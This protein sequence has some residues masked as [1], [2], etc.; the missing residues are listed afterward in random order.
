M[1]VR[2][3]IMGIK[4]ILFGNKT[5]IVHFIALKNE[6]TGKVDYYCGMER[7]GGLLNKENRWKV[8]DDLNE[9]YFFS[10]SESAHNR[11]KL[12]NLDN[13]IHSKKEVQYIAI[14]Q[15]IKIK[16]DKKRNVKIWSAVDKDGVKKYDEGGY[17]QERIFNVG[18]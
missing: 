17:L 5:K 6:M 10:S 14:S 8:T 4:D 1:N 9:A 11:L 18:E 3:M 12:M 7:V 15:K 13:I 16:D 2:R